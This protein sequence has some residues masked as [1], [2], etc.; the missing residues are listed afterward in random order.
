MPGE[1]VQTFE[2]D[3]PGANTAG[4]NTREIG[5]LPLETSL[6]MNESWGFNIT[7]HKYKSPRELIGY[8][9]RAAGNGANLLLNIGPRPDGTIQPEAEER[10]RAIGSWLATYG[11]SI[12]GTRAGPIAPRSWG[13]TTQRGTPCSCTCSI[14]RTQRCAAV[15][16]RGT[17]DGAEL[18]GGEG[19]G[20]GAD[21][22]RDDADVTGGGGGSAG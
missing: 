5:G 11:G 21:G 9:V 2:Q 14:G 18:A 12:Y 7:D 10:L 22:G 20:A 19:S 8:L 1:D 4:F 13:V 15:T 6:T 3:L 16:R 17:V